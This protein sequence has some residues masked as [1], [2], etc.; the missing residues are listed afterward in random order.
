MGVAIRTR[1]NL[2]LDL[3]SLVWKPLVGQSFDSSDLAAIDEI[4][5]TVCT[6]YDMYYGMRNF[7]I[8]SMTRC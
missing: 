1:T 2:E 3:P 4:C 7:H 8:Y 6:L 5:I